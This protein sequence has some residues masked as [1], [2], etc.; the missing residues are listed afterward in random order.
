MAHLVPQYMGVKPLQE[1]LK[2][3]QELLKA[4]LK[5]FQS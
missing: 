1:I 4:L 3:F 5:Y 2:K